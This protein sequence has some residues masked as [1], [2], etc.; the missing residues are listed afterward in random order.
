MLTRERQST[1]IAQRW[2]SDS[3]RKDENWKYSLCW[4]SITF[5][6]QNWKVIK[7]LKGTHHRSRTVCTWST[8]PFSCIL[9]FFFTIMF[10]LLCLFFLTL[11]L[12]EFFMTLVENKFLQREWVFAF[13]G[14][15][16]DTNLRLLFLAQVVW[17]KPAN[18]CKGRLMLTNSQ[19]SFPP[20]PSKFLFFPLTH[21]GIHYPSLVLRM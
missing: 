4:K 10:L 17:S 20:S 15:L 6:P 16:R 8:V 14:N 3:P 1:A 11:Y 18:L 5:I 9:W 2:E 21:S 7:W 12:Q 13:P 19:E